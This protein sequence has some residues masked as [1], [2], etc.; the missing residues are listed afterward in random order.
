L[1]T[2]IAYQHHNSYRLYSPDLPDY[3]VAKPLA[4]QWGTVIG[5]NKIAARWKIRLKYN[6]VTL[7]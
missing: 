4:I 1:N 2:I 5:E 3:E 6:P 7:K